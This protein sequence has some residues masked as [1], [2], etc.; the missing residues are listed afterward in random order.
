MIGKEYKIERV[1]Y[2]NSLVWF[3]FRKSW[4]GRWKRIDY[5]LD[6]CISPDVCKL[7]LEE[8]IE[9]HTGEIVSVNLSGDYLGI[10]EFK[11]NEDG[12][13]QIAA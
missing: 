1:E 11:Y 5:T 7:R 9:F 13:L 10:V 8:W 2:G 3:A 6:I 4:F 12:H